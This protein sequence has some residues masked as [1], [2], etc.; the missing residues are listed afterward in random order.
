MTLKAEETHASIAMKYAVLKH[1]NGMTPRI[2][3]RWLEEEQE[4]QQEEQEV[5]GV[6]LA[7]QVH[8][9]PQNV[10][11]NVGLVANLGT[12]QTFVGK[13]QPM[14]DPKELEELQKLFKFPILKINLCH[15]LD[16]HLKR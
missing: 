14:E 1:L 5:V 4:E 6:R 8:M 12:L 11:G 9:R 15:Q 2:R 3:P 16:Q 10:G 13:I 7:N